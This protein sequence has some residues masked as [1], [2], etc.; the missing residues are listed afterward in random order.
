MGSSVGVSAGKTGTKF[1]ASSSITGHV[2]GH[3]STGS[4]GS[5]T[6]SASVPPTAGTVKG[7][8]SNIRITSA[9]GNLVDCIWGTN[10]TYVRHVRGVSS[11]FPSTLVVV[12]ASIMSVASVS[13]VSGSASRSAHSPIFTVGC[14]KVK[15]VAIDRSPPCL[16]CPR[17]SIGSSPR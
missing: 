9:S 3:G 15:E 10:I 7:S 11:R 12:R 8:A 17:S 1:S 13:V 5:F 6:S 2:A 14:V 16:L 4:I